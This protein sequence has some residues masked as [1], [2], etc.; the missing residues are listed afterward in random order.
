MKRNSVEC[1]AFQSPD[2]FFD[3]YSIPTVDRVSAS[4]SI[5]DAQNALA[6]SLN[7]PPSM[8][9]RPRREQLELRLRWAKSALLGVFRDVQSAKWQQPISGDD[10]NI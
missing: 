9:K 5:L 8:Q 2:G 4:R 7:I 3:A 10:S 6:E 1:V